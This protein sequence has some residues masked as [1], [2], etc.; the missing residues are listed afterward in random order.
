[1]RNL[2][3][4][5]TCGALAA[6]L[7]ASARADTTVVNGFFTSDHCTGNCGPQAGGFATIQVTDNG[8]GT[9]GNVGTLAFN[10]QLLNGNSLP[11][12]GQDVVFGF[13][14]IGNP[15]ITYAGLPGTFTIPGGNPQ[16]V[17]T[18]AA[19]GFG[20]FGYGF[21]LIA[22]GPS[23]PPIT[24]LLFSISGVNLDWTDLAKFSTNPPGDTPA[25][26]AL[27]ILSG[28]TGKTGFVDL[29]IA[30]SVNQQCT[31]CAVPA[32]LAGAGLP[33]VIAACG[34][35]IAVARRRGRVTALRLRCPLQA[36][37]QKPGLL[38][39]FRQGP[40]RIS[41][42]TNCKALSPSP[43]NDA[44]E[45]WRKATFVLIKNRKHDKHHRFPKSTVP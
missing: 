45:R 37:V 29:S 8:L 13:N 36:P 21:D 30:P 32:P 15:A 27:D 5:L 24:S 38:H 12:G 14:L 7:P 9:G 2:L 10:I 42:P 28:T 23:N 20:T 11:N 19:D 17:Q 4:A 31:S 1:M 26:M 33:G 18:L 3:F 39:R 22:G 34:L 35:L 40:Q 16:S 44:R 41:A 6:A 43:S 25:I